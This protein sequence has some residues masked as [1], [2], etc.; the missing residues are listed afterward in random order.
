MALGIDLGTTFSAAAYVDDSGNVVIIRTPNNPD[1]MVPSAVLLRGDNV[2]VG[3]AA[4]NACI[5]DEAHV[6]RWIKRAIGNPEYQFAR[7]LLCVIPLALAADLDGPEPAAT[8]SAPADAKPSAVPA[9]DALRSE[10]ARQNI[11]LDADA[12][13]VA[14]LRGGDWVLHSGPAAFVV[15]LESGT[16]NVY[17]GMNAIQISA[18]ILKVIKTCAENQLGRRIDEVVITHPAYFNAIE[19][20]NTRKAGELAGLK[21]RTTVEEPVAAAVYY[22]VQQMKDGE[23]TLVCDLGGGTFDATILLRKGDTFDPL[24]TM[25]DRLLGGHDW[26]TRLMEMA[27]EEFQRQFGADPRDDLIAKQALYETCEAAK[28]SFSQLP[29]VS[30]AC[31]LAGQPRQV[32]IT[33]QDF[34]MRTEDLIQRMV[35]RCQT[36]LEKAAL[37]WARI[38]RILLVGGSSRLRRVTEALQEVSG[39]KPEMSQSPDLMVVY[40][41]AII[42]KGSVAR[43]PARGGLAEKRGAGG[44]AEMKPTVI[45]RLPKSLGVRVWDSGPAGEQLV[46]SLIIARDTETPVSGSSEEFEVAVDG[47][48]D[49]DIPVV[50]FEDDTDF[51]QLCN[52]RCKC[53]PNAR[54]GDRV[55]ITFT[56][57]Q[58]RQL[59]AEAHDCATGRTLE[60][61]EARFREPSAAPAQQAGWIVFAIDTSGSMEG[62]KLRAAKQMLVDQATQQIRGGGEAS[63]VGVISFNTTASVVVEPTVDLDAIRRQVEHMGT[64]GCTAMDLGLREALQL[65]DRAPAGV[66]RTIALLTDGMPDSDCR[67]R[68]VQLAQDIRGRGITLVALGVSTSS[69]DI[70]S[71]YMARLTPDRDIVQ[72]VSQMGSAMTTLLRRRRA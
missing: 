26:T 18:E 50:E 42:A 13:A 61:D 64:T 2:V 12:C 22:G 62:D 72:S 36:A 51:D 27:A 14:R 38:D 59:S 57:T 55:R 6:V 66:P 67:D 41:A 46:N 44:L 19:V 49:F 30:I 68:T 63:P 10:L 40:G 43:R 24:A 34:E 15:R 56:Y 69:G 28:R 32:T 48:A 20:E 4:I 3:D 21:V 53:L 45:T 33:R 71:A 8:D 60:L 37:T 47:Q 9:T 70:D 25:G 11:V 7:R 52:F 35:A 29:Q 1:T 5:T 65:V 16:L 31:T 54:R 39:K 58:N 17:E 23:R